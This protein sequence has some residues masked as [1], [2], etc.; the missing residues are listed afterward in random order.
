[1]SAGAPQN[2]G[3]LTTNVRKRKKKLLLLLLGGLLLGCRLLGGLLLS[4]H[5]LPPSLVI[6]TRGSMVWRAGS[7]V[8]TSLTISPARTSSSTPRVSP[9]SLFD[10]VS[11]T[12][13]VV[14]N[15]PRTR[16]GSVASVVATTS[17]IAIQNV[18]IHRLQ[19][20]RQ[21]I[22]KIFFVRCPV[23]CFE[24]G[25]F[26]MS[27]DLSKDHQHIACERCEKVWCAVCIGRFEVE[28]S[29]EWLEQRRA[30]ELN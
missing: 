22:A 5:A 13:A 26:T 16:V 19:P 30:A 21:E 9:R 28:I 27:L 12:L 7:T 4:H 10:E 24:C 2:P 1:M 18:L 17:S 14:R 11:E 20:S 6:R 15:G 8:E 23:K 25:T 3:A 29:R